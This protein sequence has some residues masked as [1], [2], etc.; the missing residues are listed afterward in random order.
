MKINRFL[1]AML[2]TAI[3]ISPL[4]SCNKNLPGDG[5]FNPLIGGCQVAEF[6]NSQFD[7]F[8]PTPP[9]Y[10]FRKTFDARGKIV[11]GI[12]CSFTNDILP[13]TLPSFTLH[14]S[15]VQQDRMILLINQPPG[16]E[17]DIPDI[18]GRIYLNRAGRPDSCVG[19]A[20]IDPFESEAPETEHYFY[21]NDRLLAVH[22]IVYFSSN[23]TF[24]NTDTIAYD[25]LGNPLSFIHNSYQYD[26]RR[27]EKQQFYCDDFM[28][29]DRVFYLL[30]YLGFFPEVTN[31]PNLRIRA[32]TT[33]VPQG[34]ALTNPQFDSGGKLISYGFITGLNTITW[35]CK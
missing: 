19:A 27:R 8:Y 29:R 16:K 23:G 22:D 5:F 35:D 9:P 32:A 2:L 11:T 33:D 7:M 17:G 1:S 10:L 21:K 15:V 26:Y 30:Q 20:G 4:G 18:V 13:M 28:E 31:P 12:N 14:L 3:A 34:E 6:H 24:D 25:R